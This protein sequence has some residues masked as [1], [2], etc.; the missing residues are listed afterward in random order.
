[1]LRQSKQ[2]ADIEG[3]EKAL[4]TWVNEMHPQ[5]VNVSSKMIIEIGISI[6]RRINEKLPDEM[7]IHL[8]FLTGGFSNVEG[9]GDFAAGTRRVRS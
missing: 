4:L 1:M 6:L 9:G 7:K 3:N 5:A 2:K 8:N